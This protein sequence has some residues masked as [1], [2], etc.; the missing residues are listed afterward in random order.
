LGKRAKPFPVVEMNRRWGLSK[1]VP[2]TP[3][4]IIKTDRVLSGRVWLVFHTVCQKTGW[5][6]VAWVQ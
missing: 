2:G 5:S 1:I 3:L 6:A 4:S